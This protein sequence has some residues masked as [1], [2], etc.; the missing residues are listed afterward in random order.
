MI[1]GIV[2]GTVVGTKKSDNIVGTKYQ[3]VRLCNYMAEEGSEYLVAL[4]GV[5]AG[6]DEMVIISQGSSCRQTKVTK[7]RPI[8]ALIVGIVDLVEKDGEIVFKK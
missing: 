1:F 5:G 2:V 8:D 4:D 7:E 3:L 6:V